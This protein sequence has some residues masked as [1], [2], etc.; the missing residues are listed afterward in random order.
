MP[1]APRLLDVECPCCHAKLKVDP[2][3]Q[4]VIHHEQPV[5]P[6]PVEDLAGA[7]ARLKE[8]SGRREQAF[9]K[10][11]EQQKVQQD[12]LSKKFDELLRRAKETPD[13]PPP[14]RDIDLD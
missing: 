4:A 12:V 1:R 11:V 9:Q 13:T 7:V 2:A 6:P 3:T 5:K 10:S 8:E 14:M